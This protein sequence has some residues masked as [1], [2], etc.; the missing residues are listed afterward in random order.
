[1][2]VLKSPKQPRVLVLNTSTLIVLEELGALH[3]VRKAVDNSLVKVVVPKGVKEELKRGGRNIDLP[4]AD[5]HLKGEDIKEISE[6]IDVPRGLGMGERE[7]IATAYALRRRYRVAVITDDKKAR[8]VC[9][10]LDLEVHGTLWLLKFLK[11]CGVIA[12]EEA[13]ELLNSIQDTSLYI[14]PELLSRVRKEL[15]N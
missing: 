3:Y 14:D 9:E 5:I 6:V 15:S 1:M 4:T 2:P 11:D 8:S 12:R 13:V 7:V 10:K